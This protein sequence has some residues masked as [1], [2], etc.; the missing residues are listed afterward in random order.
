MG[1]GDV[2]AGV[3]GGWQYVDVIEVGRRCLVIG[4]RRWSYRPVVDEILD[5]MTKAVATVGAM[6]ALLMVH[7]V[8]GGVMPGW[9][10]VGKRLRIEGFEMPF[11]H[12]GF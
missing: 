10:W 1:Q 9:E 5:L 3:K 6:T 12:Q 4:V 2:Y 8:L 11:F 7:T